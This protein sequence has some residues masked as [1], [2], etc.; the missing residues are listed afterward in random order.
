MKALCLIILLVLA[1]IQ[2]WAQEAFIRDGNVHIRDSSNNV[3]QLTTSGRDLSPRLSPDAKSIAFVR[4]TPGVLVGAG[5]GD[6]NATELWL[7]N[8]DTK[9]AV[10]L[11]EGKEDPQIEKTLAGF[12]SPC[13]SPDGRSI[14]FISAAWATSDAIQKI[15][16]DTKRVRFMTDG[17]ALEVIPKGEYGG[18][19]L[20]ER[21][22][23]KFDKNGDSL[24][25]DVYLWLVSP[26]GKP[27]R[28]IG[29]A[30][31]KAASDFREEHLFRIPHADDR[32]HGDG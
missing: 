24:G 23:I 14:Y 2:L 18:F 22:L 12:R 8:V 5:S 3:V 28:E 1:P 26:D 15:S 20:V 29:Q 4:D 31:S 17:I 9:Q 27:V 6:Q 19:L 13:F 25:R 21:A 7:V 32:R 16:L 30:E 10:L 11:A